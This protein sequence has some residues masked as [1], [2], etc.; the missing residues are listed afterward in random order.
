MRLFVGQPLAGGDLRRYSK[1][2]NF[3]E[4][5]AGKTLPKAATLKRWLTEVPE[6]FAFSVVL[7]ESIAAL[8]GSPIDEPLLA[9]SLEAAELLGARFI[10]LRTPPSA[11]PSARTRRRL[12]ELVA[13]LPK[14]S[15][16]V[17]WE[18]RGLWEDEDAEQAAEELGV[19]LVRDVSRGDAPPEDIVYTRLRALGGGG[20]VSSGAVERAA[21]ELE[22]HS[23][24]YVVVEGA[25]AVRAAKILREALGGGQPM[26]GG[27]EDGYDES[28]DDDADSDDLDLEGEEPADETDDDDDDD[29]D[30]D[31]DD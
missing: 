6:G 15:R 27:D 25:T 18:P 4:L 21:D 14:D 9:R 19:L 20:R 26:D 7:P 16:S 28:S 5:D 24:A 12:E 13:R 11:H 10:V 1:R 8:D 22:G 31:E 2:F 23:E 3:L 30:E 29:A 17:A